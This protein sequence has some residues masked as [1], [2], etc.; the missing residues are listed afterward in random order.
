MLSMQLRP[1]INICLTTTDPYLPF[2][3]WKCNDAYVSWICLQRCSENRVLMVLLRIGA[4]D[5]TVIRKASNFLRVLKHKI[6]NDFK[7]EN[8]HANIQNARQGLGTKII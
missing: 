4:K 6:S 2:I 8:F 5:L 3:A 7:K 1:G